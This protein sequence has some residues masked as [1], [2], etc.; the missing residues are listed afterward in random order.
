MI[1][2]LLVTKNSILRKQTS[3]ITEAK[4]LPRSTR[5]VSHG[6]L[7]GSYKLFC[8]C[9]YHQLVPSY[10][11]EWTVT[12]YSVHVPTTSWSPAIGV[13]ELLQTILYMYLPPV[14]PQLLVWVNCYKLLC[15]C[16]YHQLVPSYWC[17]CTAFWFGCIRICWRSY[18]R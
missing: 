17:E 14:G 2:W 1:S 13:S 5:I 15:T 9:T 16:T 11:C 18:N 12:N 8:R 10:W 4:W 6:I 7:N 3:R